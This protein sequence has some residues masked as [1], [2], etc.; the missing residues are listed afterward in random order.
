MKSNTRRFI[1]I[2]GI[3]GLGLMIPL[4]V[5]LAEPNVFRQTPRHSIRSF[6][7]GAQSSGN[8]YS[9]SPKS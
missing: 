2:V 4:K 1:A 8:L 9:P 6:K 5:A 3:I 7:N